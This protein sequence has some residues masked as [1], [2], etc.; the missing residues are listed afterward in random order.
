MWAL[1]LQRRARCRTG[2]LCLREVRLP[3]VPSTRHLRKRPTDTPEKLE[4]EI[5]AG[6]Q[7]EVLREDVSFLRGGGIR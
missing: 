6:L 1:R 3:A 2:P 5:L 4:Q 7:R